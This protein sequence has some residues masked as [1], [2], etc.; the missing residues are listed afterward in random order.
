[1]TNTDAITAK[2]LDRFTEFAAITNR[3]LADIDHRAATYRRYRVERHDAL[4]ADIAD[5]RTDIDRL[6]AAGHNC[7]TVLD[8]VLASIVN[9]TERIERL[10]P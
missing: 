10:E 1:M 2:Y 3:R 9:L 6:T 7:A 4:A 8:D 5:I